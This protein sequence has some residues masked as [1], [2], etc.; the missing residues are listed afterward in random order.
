MSSYEPCL[1]R[2]PEVAKA[3]T[4]EKDGQAVVVDGLAG[5]RT[6]SAVE[7][8]AA[9]NSLDLN[10]M[11]VDD[12]IAHAENDA[13]LSRRECGCESLCRRSLGKSSA[14]DG[15]PVWAEKSN[16]G[17][18]PVLHRLQVRSITPLRRA[19]EKITGNFNT[20]SSAPKTPEPVPGQRWDAGMTPL[21]RTLAADNTFG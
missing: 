9:K 17:V 18:D 2:T 13:A 1:R 5:A 6:R 3:M 4:Y 8:Y 16:K 12:L 20:R 7:A 11:S 15:T 21:E 10:T 14:S 19:Q